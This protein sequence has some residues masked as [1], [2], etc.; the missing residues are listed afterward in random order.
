MQWSDFVP[1]RATVAFLALLALGFGVS[2]GIVI[3]ISA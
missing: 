1:S 3:F 2:A